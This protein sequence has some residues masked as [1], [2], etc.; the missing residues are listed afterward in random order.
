MQQTKKINAQHRLQLAYKVNR[1]KKIFYTAESGMRNIWW[2]PIFLAILTLLLFPLILIAQ[3]RSAD[4][5]VPVQ[6]ILLIVVTI[7]CQWLRGKSIIEVTGKINLRWLKQLLLG[8]FI[9]VVLMLL[10]AL[11][12]T[13]SGYTNWQISNLSLPVFLSGLYLYAGVALAEELLF[14]GFI[15][16]RLIQSLGQWPAQ[17]IIAGMFLLTHISNPGMTGSVKIFASVNIFIA[18][19]LFGLAYIKTQSL[20]MPIGLH[21]M[22]N[23]TQGTILGFGVSGNDGQSMFNAGITQCPEWLSGGVF[24]L[25]ASFPGLFTVICITILLFRWSAIPFQKKTSV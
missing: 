4:V 3:S 17:L 24:G 23:V 8:A 25:E 2:V 7:I 16:Q 11:I 19:V 13:I 12:L 21:L 9:G 15:F 1:I 20:A 5:S 6:A 18:S 10:P 22:A 14:R